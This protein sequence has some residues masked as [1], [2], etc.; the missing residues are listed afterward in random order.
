MIYLHQ[1]TKINTSISYA[2]GC[3]NFYV[4]IFEIT[5]ENENGHSET[6]YIKR[7]FGIDSYLTNIPKTHVMLA[8]YSLA[9]CFA[10]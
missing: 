3:V 1:I 5:G 8:F 10:A 2:G 7:A 6:E 4:V 9:K